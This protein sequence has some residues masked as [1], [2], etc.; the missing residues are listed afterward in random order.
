MCSKDPRNGSRFE[1]ETESKFI[2]DLTINAEGT[3]TFVRD[4]A[5]SRDSECLLY[6]HLFHFSDNYSLQ[7]D[8]NYNS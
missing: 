7:C 8:I 4:S 1:F 2:R 6:Q 3:G 5:Y